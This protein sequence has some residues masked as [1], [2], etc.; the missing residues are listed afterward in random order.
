MCR[1]LLP[2]QSIRNG[3][4]WM[5]Y[6]SDDRKG[7]TFQDG[8]PLRAAPPNSRLRRSTPMRRCLALIDTHQPG[9]LAL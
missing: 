1:R 7:D 2:V 8:F 3:H 6:T 9:L 5:L 4:A